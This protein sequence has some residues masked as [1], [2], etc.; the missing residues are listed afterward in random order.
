MNVS[1]G[2]VK[3]LFDSVLIIFG[4]IGMA[5]PDIEFNK[6]IFFLLTTNGLFG[7]VFGENN[8][9]VATHGN[10][11]TACAFLHGLATHELKKEELDHV[12]PDYQVLITIRAQKK[13]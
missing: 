6:A 8:V 4:E 2:I 13:M 11:L 1:V 7:D 10:V 3:S 5:K 9:D 12:D